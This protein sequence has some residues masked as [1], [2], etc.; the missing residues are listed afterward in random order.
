[1]FSLRLF[2]MLG[3]VFLLG[4][5]FYLLEDILVPFVVAWVLAYLLV[6]VVD[7]LDQY[8][9]RWLAILVSFLTLATLLSGVLFGL[10]PVLQAQI[11]AFLAQLPGYVEQ[12][13]RMVAGLTSHFHLKV[14]VGV[15]SRSVQDRIVQL[16]THLLQAPSVLM[17]TAAHLIKTI[18]FIALVP[19]VAFFLLRDWHQ[20]VQGIESFVRA[21][22]RASLEQFVRT[23][24]EVLRHYL[25][26]ELLV[27]VCV[28]I[29][30]TIGY[31]IT[32]ISLGLVLGMLA[33]LV[34]VIPFASFVLAGIPAILLAIV[35]FHDIVHPVMILLT[36]GVSELIGNGV[37][38]PVLV[39]RYVRVHPAAVLLF[40]FAG[41]ALFGVLGMVMALP[42]AA[43]TSAWVSTLTDATSSSPSPRSGDGESKPAP[44]T[45]CPV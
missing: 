44:P 5:G 10:V 7:L 1:M 43:I 31:E 33:G 20:L 18:I 11:S 27:M 22:R 30:Y 14:D 21:S 37:L 29:M 28:G 24:D 25:H 32:G 12:L 2:A 13:N 35:Q 17:S 16:G 36:I 19:V 15:L 8:L 4:T 9:P 42:L 26:G 40:I 39:G 41:G 6:P 34:F 3:S 38:T 23:A 45:D